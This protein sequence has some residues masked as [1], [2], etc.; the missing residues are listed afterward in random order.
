VQNGKVIAETTEDNGSRRLNLKANVKIDG[1]SWLAARCGGPQYSVV[2]HHDGWQRGVFAHTSP[3]YI[4][5]GGEWWMFD[6]TTAEYMLTLI[7]GGLAHIHQRA[8]HH[9]AHSVT[10]HHGEQDHMAYLEAPFQQAI[11]A[12]HKRM[13]DLGIPH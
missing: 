6:K 5:V 3:V 2:P 12:I 11:A 8:A 4:A 7:E 1:H 10:H 9:P 13:H